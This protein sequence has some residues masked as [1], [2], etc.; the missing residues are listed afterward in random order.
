M[1][2]VLP[3]SCC[4]CN[5]TSLLQLSFVFAVIHYATA[6]MV[7]TYTIEATKGGYEVTWIYS[8]GRF[9][10]IHYAPFDTAELKT[11]RIRNTEKRLLITQIVRLH[12]E[13]LY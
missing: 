8:D 12:S 5:E 2:C 7:P 6:Q 11:G 4:F 9:E 3:L 13:K 10:V 1:P